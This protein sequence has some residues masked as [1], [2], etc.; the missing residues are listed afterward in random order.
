VMV[1]LLFFLCRKSRNQS[2][3]NRSPQW[4]S[5]DRVQT[6]RLE[7]YTLI[8]GD[9]SEQDAWLPGGQN[10]TFRLR[11]ARVFRNCRPGSPKKGKKNAPRYGAPS[12]VPRELILHNRGPCCRLLLYPDRWHSK[13]SGFGEACK[14][15]PGS[16]CFHRS[17]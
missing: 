2:E 10:R 8:F 3:P 9:E 11:K 13:K 14:I 7:P 16:Q 17:S 1:R 4:A 6:C 12:Q 15:K 5:Q